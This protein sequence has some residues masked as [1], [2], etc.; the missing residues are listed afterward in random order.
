MSAITNLQEPWN[1]HTY[2]EVEDFVTGK[3]NELKEKA[4]GDLAT[5]FTIEA[6]QD[7]TTIY[8]RQSSYAA[9]DGLDPLNVEISTDNGLTWTEVTASPANGEFL[10]ST[11]ATLDSGEKVVVRGNNGAYGYYS[12]SMDDLVENC[13]FFADAPCYVYGNI[14]SLVSKEGFET[15][16][17]VN[18]Y[19]FAYFFS[20]YNGDYDF[21]W[22]LSKDGT[23]LLLPATTLASDCYNSMFCNC[24]SLT[25]APALPATTLADRCYSSM[26]CACT[27]LTTAPVLPATTLEYH[28]Y[29][30]MFSGCTSLT[31]APAIP[32]TT[33]ADRCYDGMFS[34]CTSLTTAPALPATTL[35]EYC[36]SSMFRSC[37]SLTAAPVLP[38]TTLAKGCYDNMFS[39]CTS[40][41]VAPV[42]PATT[43]ADGCYSSMFSGCTSLAAAPVLPAT[44]LAD[45]CYSS[46]FSGCTSL[47]TAPE[48]PAIKLAAGCYRNMFVGCSNLS[49]IKA[50]FTTTPGSTYTLN[51]VSGVKAT[52]TF[53]KSG[54][55]DWDVT[56]SSGIPSGWTVSPHVDLTKPFTIEAAI[57]GTKVY[58]YRSAYGQERGDYTVEVSTDGG[59]TWASKTATAYGDGGTVIAN[60]DAGESAI[61]RG[62][63]Q[64]YGGH[65]EEEDEYV[66]FA[67]FWADKPCYVYGNIMS[68]VGGANFTGLNSMENRGFAFFFA[69]YDSNYGG[70]WVLSKDGAE[71]LLPATTLASNCYSNMFVGCTSLTTAP[72]LPATTLADSCYNGMFQSCTSLTAAPVLQATILAIYC[73][74]DMFSHCTSLTTAPALPATTLADRCYSGMFSDCTSLTT[75]PALPATT[76]ASSCY[77]YMFA[78]CTSL[79]TAPVL[80]ATT[81]LNDCYRS[82][83]SGC[84]SLT[85][86]PE[87]P[88]TTLANQCYKYMFGDCTSLKVAP[89]LPATTLASSCYNSMFFRC[90]SL[91]AAPVLPAT[92][93]TSDCYNSMFYGCTN[94]SYIKALFTTTPGSGSTA[95]WVYGVKATGTFVKSAS[96]TWNVTG[97][98]GVPSGWEIKSE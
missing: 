63:N 34:G 25:V 14:M 23:E 46:M 51:W 98:N 3:I 2:K 35:A 91:T 28:C 89:A 74:A 90:T 12:D 92:T 45:G 86:A 97:N 96:A 39:V 38:A 9:E 26:F 64:V 84:T 72:E 80:P 83:F 4:Y 66:N 30:G 33:L 8:F 50:L 1:G 93:L 67:N 48:L 18:E 5:P 57:N 55:A 15:L 31:A 61:I 10:G 42:L 22:V 56:G 7:G 43:L 59:T 87:L 21:S 49:Y 70:S 62:T 47:T 81:L 69:D 17:S 77:N 19:A 37:T 76:L 24:T 11:L 36:Y 82:M 68:L 32:A 52:G 71:L 53:I 40:L 41:T 44:T 54:Y 27:S 20:D 6:T 58:F 79:T 13:Q 78:G 75:A 95:T 88:A 85:T 29:L 60:L 94:L 73:Y 65:D 16:R